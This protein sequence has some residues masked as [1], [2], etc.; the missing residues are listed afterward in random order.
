M[1]KE[2]GRNERNTGET[3]QQIF[4]PS[5]LSKDKDFLR[6]QKSKKE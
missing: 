3:S 6:Q 2:G 5:F 4:S 1:R